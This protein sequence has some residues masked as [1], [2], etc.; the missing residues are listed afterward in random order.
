MRFFATTILVLIFA[1]LLGIQ[2]SLSKIEK[3][4]E[5]Q[6]GKKSDQIQP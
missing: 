3:H 4:L 6:A 1:T 5:S 2:Q